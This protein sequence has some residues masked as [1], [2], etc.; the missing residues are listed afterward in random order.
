[1][2]DAGQKSAAELQEPL[3][4][5]ALAHVPFDGWGQTALL[6]GRATSA[7]SAGS[8]STPSPAGRRR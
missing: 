7:S 1:M 8:P 2:T 4:D 3:I 5:A 6:A